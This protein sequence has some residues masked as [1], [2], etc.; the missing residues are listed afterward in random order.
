MMLTKLQVPIYELNL[1]HL[2]RKI[3]YRPYLSKEERIL[4]Y[5]QESGDETDITNAVHQIVRNCVLD[6]DLDID[7]LPSFVIDYI[8]IM[9]KA[10]SSGDKTEV[11]FECNTIPEGKEV[12]CGTSFK[13]ELKVTDIKM[14]EI[15]TNLEEV[16]IT[17]KVSVALTYPSFADMKKILPT[18]SDTE[19]TFYLIASSIAHIYEEGMPV[20]ILR[21]D[22]KYDELKEFLD[23]LTLEQFS[24]FEKHI[25]SIPTFSIATSK[26]CPKCGYKHDFVFNDLP[27]FF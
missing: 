8:F 14:P 4:R 20:P 15:P 19:R 16:K 25:E 6:S 9:A 26:K 24:I 21:K 1:P 11:E 10:K 5:A 7:T 27:S 18:D 13:V 2:E 12:K 23:N 3:S 22:I 17:D